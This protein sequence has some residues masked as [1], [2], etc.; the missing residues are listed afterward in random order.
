MGDKSCYNCYCFP[1][2]EVAKDVSMLIQKR[3]LDRDPEN[4]GKMMEFIAT[5]MCVLYN[6]LPNHHLLV[7]GE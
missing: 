7:R 5:E 4:N 2:C 3:C 6:P 1:V